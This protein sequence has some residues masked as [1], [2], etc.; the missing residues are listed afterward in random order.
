MA[1][2]FSLLKINVLRLKKAG[3]MLLIAALLSACDD[4]PAYNGNDSGELTLTPIS[5]GKFDIMGWARMNSPGA[6][7][8]LYIEG[9]GKNS[10]SYRINSDEPTPEHPIAQQ[11]AKQDTSGNVAYL[12]RPCQFVS[13]SNDRGCDRKYWHDARYSVDVVASMADAIRQMMAQSGSKSVEL[14]GV[15]GGGVVAALVALRMPEV[16]EIR[17]LGAPMDLAAWVYAH[18]ISPL[19]QSLAPEDNI[20]M[21]ATIPQ[22]HIVSQQDENVPPSILN[23][24][25]R[26]LPKGHCVKTVTVEGPT[27]EE[28]WDSTWNRYGHA[29]ISCKEIQSGSGA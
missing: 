24:Y 9:D 17:T 29:P 13:G 15:G 16:S 18:H 6:R 28:G 8:R 27:H 4:A 3:R 10:N 22:L 25:M 19:V 14:I 7:L 26:R 21:L 12:A 11:L 1:A 2:R 20:R 5:A 23:S